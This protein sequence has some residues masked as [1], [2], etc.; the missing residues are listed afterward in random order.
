MI[1]A[2]LFFIL[3]TIII[4]GILYFVFFVLF[5]SLNAQKINGR[6]PLF[7]KEDTA[8]HTPDPAFPHVDTGMKAIVL[9]SPERSFE[10]KRFDYNGPADCSLFY[11]LY[12]NE[13]D[14][15]Y[16]CVGFGNCVRVCPRSAIDI[17]NGTAIINSMCNGCGLCEPSC[18]KHLIKL[19]P[20]NTKECEL[21]VL[22]KDEKNNCSQCHNKT[23]LRQKPTKLFQFWKKFYTIMNTKSEE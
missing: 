12:D 2:I 4:S 17:T 18:P 1:A 11:S 9:C 5:P 10:A 20:Q 14:C 19:I 7:S 15:V 13:V 21:C 22:P 23:K 8:H 16:G 6:R 3:F